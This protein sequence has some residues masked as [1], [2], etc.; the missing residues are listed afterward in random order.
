MPHLTVEQTPYKANKQAC[1]ELIDGLLG[2]V[3]KAQ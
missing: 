3:G 1:K 2:S